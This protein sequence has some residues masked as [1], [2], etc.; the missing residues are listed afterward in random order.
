MRLLAVGAVD[1]APAAVPAVCERS[2][3]HADRRRQ[4]ERPLP[5]NEIAVDA[6]AYR[7]AITRAVSVVGPT[8]M[9]T[10]DERVHDVWGA[11]TPLA[12]GEAWPARVDEYLTVEPEA[13]ERWVRSACVLCS[14]GCGV[15]VAVAGG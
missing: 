7:R 1:P 3:E 4:R 6:D 9:S 10:G 8:A 13:V 11:R 5:R 15:D 12:R 2:M 14:N